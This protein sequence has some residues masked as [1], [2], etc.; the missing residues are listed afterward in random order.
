MTTWAGLVEAISARCRVR[1]S[2][3]E[4]I[5]V[6]YSWDDGRSQLL[7]VVLSQI[8]DE[9]L[10]ILTSPIAPYSPANI[11]FLIQNV[12]VGLKLTPDSQISMIHPLHIAHMTDD[13]CIKSMSVVAEIADE[14]EK[15]VT[16][17]GDAHIPMPGEDVA[18]HDSGQDSGTAIPVISSGQWIVGTDI[19]PGLYRYSGY[20]ARLDAQM[21]IIE[22]D[23]A[24]SGLGL[25]KVSPHDAYFEVNGEAVRLEDYPVF[26]VLANSPRDGK[27][28][29]GVDIPVG[30]YRIHGDG[31][32]A[33]YQLMDR[34][35]QR[36]TNDLNRGSLILDLQGSTF[37]VGF[38]GR[39]ERI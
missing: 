2:G 6:V 8:A 19:S 21:G 17:G 7:D 32:S 18:S 36:V 34:N 24:R 16:N 11:D 13:E 1:E 28:L 30:K 12:E 5:Q 9:P 38:S 4:W 10:A 15:T 35:M 33:Y 39:L 27:Y 29:V 26:D 25:I 23:N 31:S 3:D 14:I 22:N 20:V 37:A